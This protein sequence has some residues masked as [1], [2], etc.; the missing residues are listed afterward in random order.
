LVY[1]KK[2]QRAGNFQA[3]ILIEDAHETTGQSELLPA[4]IAT[5][6]GVTLAFGVFSPQRLARYWI[7]CSLFDLCPCGVVLEVFVDATD[8]TY[9]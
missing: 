1:R 8:L 4:R 9:R 7:A 6:R 3:V 2:P 5:S